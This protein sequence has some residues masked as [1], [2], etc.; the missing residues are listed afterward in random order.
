MAMVLDCSCGY[1]NQADIARAWDELEAQKPSCFFKCN[2]RLPASESSGRLYCSSAELEY[3][4][5]VPPD[6]C[7]NKCP[8]RLVLKTIN[9]L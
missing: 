3:R 9:Q 2:L 8:N 1:Q 7:F 6:L 5:T 4:D